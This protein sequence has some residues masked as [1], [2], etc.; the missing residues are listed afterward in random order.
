M[1][2]RINNRFRT[3]HFHDIIECLIAALE[4]KDLYTSGHSNRVA[5]MSLDL[6][7]DMGLKC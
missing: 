1:I 3:N 6:A 2:W 4:A 5:D 7:R